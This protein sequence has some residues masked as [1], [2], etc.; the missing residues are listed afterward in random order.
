MV[1][2][3]RKRNGRRRGKRT[4]KKQ[5]GPMIVNF[6]SNPL[7]NEYFVRM[8]YVQTYKALSSAGASYAGNIFRL[9]SIYDPDESGVGHQ[10]YGHDTL[11]PLFNL[12]RVL[13][14]KIV[15]EYQPEVP[16]TA[17]YKPIIGILPCAQLPTITNFNHLLELPKSVWKQTDLNTRR[18]SKSYN[19]ANVVGVTKAQYKTDDIFMATVGANPSANCLAYVYIGLGNG[20]SP[21]IDYYVTVTMIF[22]VMWMNPKLQAQS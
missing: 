2:H 6:S 18:V 7:P 10:P 8:K 3:Q 5:K 21:T 1:K 17:Y 11:A 14:T 16:S 9:N 20:G 12:Y 19:L 22:D 13:K 4:T 15:V